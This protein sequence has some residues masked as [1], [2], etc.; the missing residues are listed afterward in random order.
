MTVA[1]MSMSVLGKLAQTRAAI[2]QLPSNI[3]LSAKCRHVKVHPIAR[4]LR[5][6]LFIHFYKHRDIHYRS[7]L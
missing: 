6:G 5:K 7:Y 2:C 3:V 1:I 4:E